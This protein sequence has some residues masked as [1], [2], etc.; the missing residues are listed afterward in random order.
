MFP[1]A[2][3]FN[4]KEFRTPKF[5]SSITKKERNG[6]IFIRDSDPRVLAVCGERDTWESV[7][8]LAHCF[9]FET[10]ENYRKALMLLFSHSVISDSL[11][12]CGLQH[13]RLPCPS[14]SS[15]TCSNSCPLNW[16]CH[17]TIS[18][19]VTPFSYPQSFPAPES[20]PMTW[21]FASDGQNIGASAS[22]C[23]MSIQGWY[24]IG[25]TGL[26]SL[27]SKGFSKVFSS[28]TIRKYQFFLTKPSLWSD[29]LTSMHDY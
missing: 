9:M 20:F 25:W 26:V 4:L 22:I 27:L 3:F 5:L 16:W 1:E 7:H 14:P 8:Y 6:H 12:P 2:K 19:S 21:L 24:P 28:T 29:S 11:H 13:A 18:S 10:I 15:G 17:P 23:P